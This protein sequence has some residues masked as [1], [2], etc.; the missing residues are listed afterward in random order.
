MKHIDLMIFDLDGTLVNSGG[1]IVASVNYT[2]ETLAIPAKKP[3]EILSFVGD[4]VQKLIERSLGKESQHLSD[5]AMDIFSDYYAKHMLDT[6]SLYDSVI[7]VLDHFRDK[8]K[9]II[10]CL[11]YTSDAADE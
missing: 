2:L 6:T 7:E 9:V 4:G 11:L 8:K 1:D 5:D 3:K 10:T